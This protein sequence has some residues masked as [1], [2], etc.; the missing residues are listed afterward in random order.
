MFRVCSLGECDPIA[1]IINCSDAGYHHI[2]D[3]TP[4]NGPRISCDCEQSSGLPTKTI[5]QVMG[6]GVSCKR[7]SQ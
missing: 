1:W 6:S 4:L 7:S 2:Y 3:E 5:T